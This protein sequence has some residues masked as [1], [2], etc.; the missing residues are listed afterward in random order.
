MYQMLSK[1]SIVSFEF[2][3]KEILITKSISNALSLQK[4]IEIGCKE[5][6]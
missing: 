4:N 2:E 5:N 1:Y 6:I 3:L